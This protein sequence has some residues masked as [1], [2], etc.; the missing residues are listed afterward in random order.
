[1]QTG[2]G[3]T[4]IKN[5]MMLKDEA[6]SSIL[7]GSIKRA[8]DLQHSEKLKEACSRFEQ[9]LLHT[10]YAGMKKTVDK[11]GLL[12]GGFAEEVFE[13]MLDE[14]LMEEAS[15]TGSFGIA[16]VLYRQLGK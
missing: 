9:M 12:S 8:S 4:D 1:M 3:G 10:M 7:K 11:S 16:E 13:S 2:L 5:I 15:R 6:N 14:K